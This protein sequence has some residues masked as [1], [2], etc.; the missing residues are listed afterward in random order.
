MVSEVSPDSLKSYINTLVAFGARSTL[1]TQ[2]D[3]TTEQ[4][5]IFKQL[6]THA[7]EEILN[8]ISRIPTN[9]FKSSDGR[10]CK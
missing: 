1:S 5:S 6:P 3:K 7:K 10:S 2:S 8:S 4:N 9:L